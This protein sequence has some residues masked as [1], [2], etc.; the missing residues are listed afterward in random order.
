[1][2]AGATL[3]ASRPEAAAQKPSTCATLEFPTDE[4]P[5]AAQV[6]CIR[7][8]PDPPDVACRA[9]RADQQQTGGSRLAA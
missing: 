4:R 9:A 8:S 6:D 7:S 3:H 2:G 5:Y 1:M